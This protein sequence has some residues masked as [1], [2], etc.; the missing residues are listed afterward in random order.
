MSNTPTIYLARHATPDWDRKDIRYDAPPGP[1]LVA[2]G[3]DEAAQL[4]ELFRQAGVHLIYVSPYLRTLRTAEIAAEVA[5]APVS[6]SEAL[7]EYT[8]EDNDSIV[9][10]RLAPFFDSAWEDAKTMGPVAMITHGGPVRVL[11]EKLGASQDHL[12]HYR[13]QFDHQNPI[14]PAGAWAITRPPNPGAW[15]VRLAFAPC[16]YTEYLPE[17]VYL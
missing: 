17:I 12:W 8:R 9:Y 6:V 15:Q 5:G 13:R 4:G 10:A 16:T 11:L 14:P 1:P 3:E 2:Q 7:S